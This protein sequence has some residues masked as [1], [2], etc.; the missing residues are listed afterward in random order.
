VQAHRALKAIHRGT[1]SRTIDP[2]ERVLGRMA[3]QLEYAELS[4]IL[5][6]GVPGYLRK[7]SDQI[8]EAAVAVQKAYFLQ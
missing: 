3:A 4:E 5:A 6:V 8:A 2:A 7:I 1:R